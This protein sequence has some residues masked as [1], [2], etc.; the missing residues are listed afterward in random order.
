MRPPVLPPHISTADPGSYARHTVVGRQPRIIDQV[1]ESNHLDASVRYALQALKRELRDG[2]I[3]H[4]FADPTAPPSG[5]EKEELRVWEEQIHEN[6]GR[7]WLDL[8]WFFAESYFYLRLL[9]SFGYYNGDFNPTLERKDPFLPQKE[10]ELTGAHGGLAV[11][12]Q[13]LESAASRG[14]EEALAFHLHCALWGNRLDL[15]T[16]DINESRRKNVLWQESGQLLVDHTAEAGAALRKAGRICFLLDNAGP[17]LVCDLL[18]TDAL[19]SGKG[20]PTV[21]LHAKKAPFFVSDATVSDTFHTID[22]LSGESDSRVSSTG[23]R[24]RVAML[25]GRLLVKDHW[26]WNSALHFTAFPADLRKELAGFDLLV[27]KGDANYRRTLE[28]RKWDTSLSLDELADYFPAP[29]VSLRTMKSEI[30]VDVPSA[31][32]E[33]L[34]GVDP[35]WMVNGKRG[36]VRYCRIGK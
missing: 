22:M 5:L 8:P 21:V 1:I 34:S 9:T 33:R 32:A 16:F 6:E 36:L 4:P 13:V 7:H 20:Q 17:E 35:E 18:L 28:D 29:F 23:E 30:V 3:R 14:A 26:F 24:L 10:R 25:S 27:V 19:L 11:A 31:V 12:R 15:S 2:R